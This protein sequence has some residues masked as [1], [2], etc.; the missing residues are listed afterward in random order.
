MEPK[1][2]SSAHDL[3]EPLLIDDLPQLLQ[4]PIDRISGR[5]VELTSGGTTIKI[6]DGTSGRLRHEVTVG[7]YPAGVAID[8]QS[9]RIFVPSLGPIDRMRGP[10]GAGSLQVVDE[11]TL[12]LIWEPAPM[13][14]STLSEQEPFAF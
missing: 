13:I 3:P 11:R 4:S 12:S 8:E 6:R 9:G 5:I 7:S 10:T 14:G 1:R 2:Y